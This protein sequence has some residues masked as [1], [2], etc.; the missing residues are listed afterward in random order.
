MTEPAGPPPAGPPPSE[1]VELSET[2][3]RNVRYLLARLGSLNDDP[4]LAV[5][6]ALQVLVQMSRSMDSDERWMVHKSNGDV[7]RLRLR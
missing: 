7:D 4:R 3:C 6:R 1:S 5:S 2:D